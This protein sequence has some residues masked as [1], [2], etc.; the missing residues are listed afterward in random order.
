MRCVSC[1][2]I[3]TDTERLSY[4]YIYDEN[5]PE[6]FVKTSEMEDM[7]HVCKH[8]M[9]ESDSYLS[10]DYAHSGLTDGITIQAKM[11]DYL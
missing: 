1:N 8:K 3:L 4:K 9:K 10:K 11:S 5:H 7:C 2:R 6:V